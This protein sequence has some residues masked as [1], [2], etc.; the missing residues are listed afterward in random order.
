MA[1][2]AG[3]AATT[4]TL[5]DLFSSGGSLTIGDKT[6]SGFGWVNSDGL[7]NSQAAALTVTASILGGVYY[8]DWSGSLTVNNTTGSSAVLGDVTL[9]YTVTANPGLI[10]MIDQSYTPVGSAGSG[11]II[12][13]ETVQVQNQTGETVGNS[14]LTLNPLYT[15]E[16]P[17]EQ[18]DNLNFS[19]ESQLFVTK[20]I[21]IAALPGYSVGLTDVEQSFHQVPEPTTMALLVFGA[22]TLWIVRK[23]RMA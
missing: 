12:I 11:Q 8:L 14:T 21:L 20:D 10:N 17:A 23:R 13:G 6:F 3:Q 1:T 9:T 16:P 18:G 7:L 19:P 15:V 2:Q 5:G 4:D 22:G